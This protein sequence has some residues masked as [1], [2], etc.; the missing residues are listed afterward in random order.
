MELHGHHRK[1]VSTQWI[2]TGQGRVGAD[3]YAGVRGYQQQFGS[4]GLDYD[5]RIEYKYAMS[6]RRLERMNVGN[7]LNVEWWGA[8]PISDG[9]T[10]VSD[11][12]TAEINTVVNEASKLVKEN[13]DYNTAYVDFPDTYYKLFRTLMPDNVILRGIGPSQTYENATVKGGVRVPPGEILWDKLDNPPEANQRHIGG[14]KSGFT[15]G[16]YPKDKIGWKNFGYDGNRRNNNQIFEN[17]D[18]YGGLGAILNALQNGGRWAGFQTPNNGVASDPADGGWD[19]VSGLTMKI[20][21]LSVRGVGGNGLGNSKSG[22]VQDANNV[23]MDR[24]Q[25]NHLYYG[26]AG[27]VENLVIEGQAWGSVVKFGSRKGNKSG[28]TKDAH[29]RNGETAN[30]SSTYKNVTFK[31]LNDNNFGWTN[32][33]EFQIPNVDIEG[34]DIDFRGGGRDGGRLFSASDEGAKVDDV[35]VWI[36]SSGDATFFKRAFYGP[37][38]F[39][40]YEITEFS[41]VTI[42]DASGNFS[43]HSAFDNLVSN[44][45]MTGITVLDEGASTTRSAL[46]GGTMEPTSNLTPPGAKRNYYE[47]LDHNP[48]TSSIY[49]IVPG[50]DI[51]TR[52]GTYPVDTF[53]ENGTFNNTGNWSLYVRKQSEAE[54]MGYGDRIY[55][56]NST[57]NIPTSGLSY[58]RFHFAL[59]PNGGVVNNTAAG[60]HVVEG[61]PIMRLRGCTTP[62]GRV[63]DSENNT[64]TSGSPSEGRDYVLIS[65]SLLGRPFEI[66]TTLASGSPNVSSITSVEVANSDGSL[67]PDDTELEHDPYLKVSLDG[68]IGTGES[69]TIDWTARVT[70]LD[71][72]STTGLFISRPVPNKTFASG[73]GPFTVDLRGVAASQETW[74]PPAYSAS[75]S[76]S[77]VVTANVTATNHRGTDRFYT[78]ELTEQGTG[79]ATITIDAEIPGV[80]T[81][82]TTFEV[83]VE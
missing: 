66:N 10:D 81:A 67:R 76:N 15:H 51:S 13:N 31:N 68:T 56:S 32:V 41:N 1:S 33:V 77:G 28:N 12:Y 79:T 6:S 35:E 24:S 49:F 54:R 65:T 60:D 43:Y 26:L 47:D 73:N 48:P 23:H 80:G 75:S 8:R 74:T 37:R 82:T 40:R 29:P 59:S 58:D 57:F 27:T 5:F 83:T 19:Y 3:G 70:P 53:V 20:D 7:G 52:L 38:T 44:N 14:I 71:Q 39:Q 63:S 9:Y 11:E 61:G 17:S 22:I 4:Q 64:F 2:Y 42:H 50:S 30:W 18:A 45:E 46:Q 62:N 21:N 72:Y 36:P 25:R 16:F 34:I 78:L 69:V 55:L